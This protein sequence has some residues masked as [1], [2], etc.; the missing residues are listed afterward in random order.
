VHVSPKVAHSYTIGT[1]D[2]HI[3][4]EKGFDKVG[5]ISDAG[6]FSV[7]YHA[8]IDTNKKEAYEKAIKKLESKFPEGYSVESTFDD[9]KGT[10]TIK[11]KK[12]KEAAEYKEAVVSIDAIK[13]LIREI[14][15]EL[16]KIK[17]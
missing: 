9:D 8:D 11:I 17:K 5:I 7:S 16:G 13:E 3:A 4:D 15:E 6:I 10:L 12:E 1:K 14:Q 2:V